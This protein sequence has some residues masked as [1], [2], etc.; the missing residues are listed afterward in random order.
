MIN[1]F[2]VRIFELKAKTVSKNDKAFRRITRNTAP[3][4]NEFLKSTKTKKSF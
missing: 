4:K 1:N 2:I 3:N